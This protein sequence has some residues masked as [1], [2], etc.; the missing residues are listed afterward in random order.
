MKKIYY[1]SPFTSRVATILSVI[2]S[3]QMFNKYSNNK[4]YRATIVDAV[5]EWS[6]FQDIITKKN[7]E[8]ICLNK[9][10]SFHKYKINGFIKSRI[11]YWY[12]FFKSTFKLHALL[13]HNKPEFLIIHL[14]TSL[15][16][17]LFFFNNTRQN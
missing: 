13:K 16:I 8:K 11:A 5:G 17:L 7:I 9:N 6:P 10:S 4:D 1:W 15:P 14:L 3:A 12:I 2:N